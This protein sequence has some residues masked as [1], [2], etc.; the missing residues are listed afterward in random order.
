MNDHMGD[1]WGDSSSPSLNKSTDPLPE[2]IEAERDFISTLFA[3]G[4]DAEAYEFGLSTPPEW[5]H[6]PQ[7]KMIWEAG[8]ALASEGTEISF[9][10]LAAKLGKNLPK[11]GG[12]QALTDIL[13]GE[14]V[15]KPEVLQD[16]IKAKWE[17]RESLKALE[18]AQK[19]IQIDGVVGESLDRL[20]S[21]ADTFEIGRAHV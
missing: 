4:R 8:I 11:V 16:I 15:E 21:L 14:E 6:K 7:H 1:L 13:S 18:M 2:A 19:A 3:P 5:F 20:R 10:T 9:A 12:F 17:A